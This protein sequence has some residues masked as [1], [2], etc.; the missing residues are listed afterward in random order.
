MLSTIDLY[1]ALPV[2]ETERLRLRPVRI[3]DAADIYAYT[4]DEET[5]RY[6]S[7]HAHDTLADSEQF[8]EHILRQYEQGNPGTLGD[9]R[10]NERTSHRND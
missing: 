4:K 8:V 5:A 3:E 2:L 1:Q 6:V 9:R 7:W 10:Q